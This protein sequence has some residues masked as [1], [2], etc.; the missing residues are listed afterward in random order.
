MSK[1][2][3]AIAAKHRPHIAARMTK[4]NG[5]NED[6]HRV[7]DDLVK[8][9]LMTKAEQ[10]DL[11]GCIE[12]LASDG[13]LGA[14]VMRSAQTGGVNTD[15]LNDVELLKEILGDDLPADG[16]DG[17]DDGNITDSAVD[18]DIETAGTARN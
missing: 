11:D 2:L 1:L 16:N 9:G 15:R 8:A 6:K 17:D 18:S 10:A 13:H 14:G 12:D 5:Y 4:E 3:K 7:S